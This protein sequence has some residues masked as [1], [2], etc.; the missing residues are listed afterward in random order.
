MQNNINE[1]IILS[2]ENVTNIFTKC[3]YKDEEIKDGTIPKD[4]VQVEGITTKFGF[5][6]DRLNE[7][8][9][10]IE[11]MIDELHQDFKKGWSFLQFC[12]DK[13]GNQWT[14]LHLT[15]EQLMVLGIAI[16]KIEYLFPREFWSV[17]PGSMPYIIIKS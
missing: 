15:M 17:L 10:N 11:Q 13:D 14:G 6:P 8:K 9:S 4:S 2:A 1:R 5:H 3:L 16:G 12:I 7:N